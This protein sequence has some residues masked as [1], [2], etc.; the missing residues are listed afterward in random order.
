[1]SPRVA[2][3]TMAVLFSMAAQAELPGFLVPMDSPVGPRYRQEASQ[4][5]ELVQSGLHWNQW[6]RVY[7]LGADASYDHNQQQWRAQRGQKSAAWY[8][9]DN[10]E[11][12]YRH[13]EP[14]AI[15]IKEGFLAGEVPGTFKQASLSLMI[16]REK[17]YDPD[18][19]DW[20]YL[21]SAPDG[22][23]LM[24]GPASSAVVNGQC[25]NCHTSVEDR[26]YVFATSGVANNKADLPD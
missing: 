12:T 19:G 14:G 6:V 7:S 24:R 8:A 13:Y 21:Q 10:S 5:S 4:V 23:V 2:A 25:G 3:L 22:Q 11:A 20:E 9:N 16:K 1:M 26:D 17:G 15:L 18:N